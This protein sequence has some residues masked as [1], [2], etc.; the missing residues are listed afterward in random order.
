MLD[1]SSTILWQPLCL[2]FNRFIHFRVCH[3]WERT[4]IYIFP[5]ERAAEV[6]QCDKFTQKRPLLIICDS[7][8]LVLLF[9]SPLQSWHKCSPVRCGCCAQL[10]TAETIFLIDL[11]KWSYYRFDMRDHREHYLQSCWLSPHS[12]RLSCVSLPPHAQLSLCGCWYRATLLIA[13]H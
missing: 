10:Y 7:N 11:F 6:L 5:S 13:A 8:R 2:S 1:E 4:E 9:F 12:H 3:Q